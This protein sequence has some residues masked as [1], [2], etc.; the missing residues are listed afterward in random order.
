[1]KRSLIITV[2]S[3]LILIALGVWLYLLFFGTPQSGTDVF[4]NLGIGGDTAPVVEQPMSTGAGQSAQQQTQVDTQSGG[5]QQLT[6]RPVAGFG[7]TGTSSAQLR[8]VERGT[9]HIYE[10]NVDT[11]AER[12]VSGTT[13]P[14]VVDA[15][16][17]P[18]AAH[19]ALISDNATVRTVLAGTINEE[20]GSTEYA[21]L[22]AGVFTTTFISE[23]N[24]GYLT[25]ESG[26]VGGYE[27]NLTTRDPVRRFTTPLTDV[28]LVWEGRPYVYNS[29][30]RHFSGALYSVDGGTTAVTP[31]GFGFVGGLNEAY[32][33]SSVI[34]DEQYVSYAT[35]RDG[36]E[37]VKLPVLF[38]PEKC[39]AVPDD[40]NRLWCAVPFE[41]TRD[42][43]ED[44]YK[45]LLRSED[46]LWRISVSGGEA[47]LISDLF[48]T[49]GR[50]VDV[51]EMI[52]SNDGAVVLFSNAT[53]NTL[54]MYD[55]R[56]E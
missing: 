32:I 56:S 11:G 43:V 26:A 49:A 23:T 24:L 16:F 15:S 42:Y 3:V 45:G 20:T 40:P 14:Q 2:G 7:F 18:E 6:T 38:L 28:H 30:T 34:E 37:R 54:W 8:Y 5:L 9:G 31:G 47:Q 25:D 46:M 51:K 19:V 35:E 10:I 4:T 22:P 1:M 13:I 33:F 44:W 27:Y 53:D 36:G 50:V 17:S 39:T 29:P 41:H 52:S 55:A 21:T 48:S 12:R